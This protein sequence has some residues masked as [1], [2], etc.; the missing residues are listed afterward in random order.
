[1]PYPISLICNYIVLFFYEYSTQLLVIKN[2]EVT[3]AMYKIIAAGNY[4][5]VNKLVVLSVVSFAGGG[6]SCDVTSLD[7]SHGF[8]A[9]VSSNVLD[10]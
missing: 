8:S 1:M 6:S 5:E 3:I 4:I 10:D 9:G 7:D 2:H